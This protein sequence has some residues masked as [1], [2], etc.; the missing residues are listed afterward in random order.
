[1]VPGTGDRPKPRRVTRTRT[2]SRLFTPYVLYASRTL[3]PPVH[4]VAL[5][6]APVYAIFFCMLVPVHGNKCRPNLRT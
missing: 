6:H 4:Y 5:T 2:G 3:V 1:M